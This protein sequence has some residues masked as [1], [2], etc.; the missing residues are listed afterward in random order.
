[1]GLFGK[2]NGNGKSFLVMMEKAE[3]GLFT[4][5]VGPQSP[6]F[7][8][9]NGQMSIGRRSDNDIVLRSTSISGHHGI[10]IKGDGTCLYKDHSKKG[11]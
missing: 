2:K 7:P 10:I 9:N 8:L 3:A 4:G 1:M 11:T 5:R 6:E